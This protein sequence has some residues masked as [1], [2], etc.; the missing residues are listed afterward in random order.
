M[1]KIRIII[2]EMLGTMILVTI[3]CGSIVQMLALKTSFLNVNLS[4]G[5]GAMIGILISAPISGGHIN[6]AVTVGLTILGRLRMRTMPIYFIGQLMGGIIG[7]ALVFGIYYEA[8][9]KIDPEL[10]VEAFNG[11]IPTGGAFGTFPSSSDLSTATLFFDQFFGT[12]ILMLLVSNVTDSKSSNI[13]P[14]LVPLFIGSTISAIGI[15]FGANCGF[16]I[17]PAR[18]FGPRLFSAIFYGRQVF[19]AFNFFFWIPIVGPIGGAVCAAFLYKF[20]FQVKTCTDSNS[21]QIDTF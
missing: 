10:T 9:I 21:I 1:E 12:F 6:P 20:L 5:L 17:N 11:S 13:P 16:A 14:A 15:S 8:L 18:D 2:A 19:S 4:F 3:G 7:A